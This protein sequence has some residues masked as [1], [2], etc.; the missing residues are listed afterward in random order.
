MFFDPAMQRYLNAG[1]S[2]GDI[3][4]GSAS[5]PSKNIVAAPSPNSATTTQLSAQNKHVTNQLKKK[6]VIKSNGRSRK[7]TSTVLA[8]KTRHARCVNNSTHLS[9]CR[10]RP[11]KKK[12][13]VKWAQPNNMLGGGGGGGG[14]GGWGH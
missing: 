10:V 14:G 9:S 8:K 7:R 12:V 11:L 4:S 1:G 5:P 3:S 6:L 2:K 13:H